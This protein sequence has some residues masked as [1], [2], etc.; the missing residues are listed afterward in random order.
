MYY[1]KAE[2]LRIEI[3]EGLNEDT[4]K[5]RSMFILLCI[6]IGYFIKNLFSLFKVFLKGLWCFVRYGYY[7]FMTWCRGQKEDREV[8]EQ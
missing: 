8:Y 7:R 3:T 5:N 2:A 4:T 1:E 6:F